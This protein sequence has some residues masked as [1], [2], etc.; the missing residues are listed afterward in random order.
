MHIYKQTAAAPAGARIVLK[1]FAF[2]HHGEILAKGARLQVSLIDISP[3]GARLRMLDSKTPP[4]EVGETFACNIKLEGLGVESGAIP[5][6][7]SWREG[8]EF[9]VAFLHELATTVSDLQ[10]KLDLKAG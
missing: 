7:T 10:K 5:C 1:A 9:G 8:S 6:R 2:N 4:P 3:G